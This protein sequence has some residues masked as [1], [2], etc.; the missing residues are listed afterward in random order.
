MLLN[1]TQFPTKI[2]SVL[3]ELLLCCAYQEACVFFPKRDNVLYFMLVP[4]F[5]SSPH[6]LQFKLSYC[7]ALSPISPKY[8]KSPEFAR[9]K[10]K[11][12]QGLRFDSNRSY[13]PLGMTF[14]HYEDQRSP[15]NKQQLL[16]A[17][18]LCVEVTIPAR[19]QALL[20]EP[21]LLL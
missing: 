16:F 11:K 13:C 3:Q 8:L 15:S 20:G 9:I 4:L 21:G 18:C 1:E 19:E 17:S 7:S 2:F 5:V 10:K 12:K 6:L 14:P